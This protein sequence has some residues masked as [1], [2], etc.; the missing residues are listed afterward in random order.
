LNNS[1]VHQGDENIKDAAKCR[2]IANYLLKAHDE[3]L[4]KEESQPI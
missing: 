4:C 2:A 3:H 1:K